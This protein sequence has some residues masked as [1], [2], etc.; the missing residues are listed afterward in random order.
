MTAAEA[1]DSTAGSRWLVTGAAGMLGQDVLAVLKDAGIEAAGLGRADL[2]ITDPASVRAAVEGAAVVVNC[3]AWT[4]VDGAES[5]EEAATAV[6]GTGVRVLAEACAAAGARLLHVSTDYVLP[7]DATEPYAEDAATGPVNAYGRSKLVGEQAV[8]ELLPQDG[9]VV[10]TAWL[11][12]EHG[13]NFVATMLKL[14]AQRDTLDVV[15]DQ[16]GQPTWSY[17]LARRLVE[18]GLAALDGRAPGGV[19]HGTASGRTTWFGLARE[20][21]RL[22]GLDPERIRPTDS[23]AFVRPAVRPSF[24]VL[25]HDRWSAA[26]LEPLADWRVQLAEAI[27]RPAFADLRGLPSQG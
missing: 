22:S 1:V 26:G 6:N 13:P 15:D 10:R 27:T 21:Y 7:G 5:A 9:Y 17:A 23:T 3:A 2:D 12:G 19:Y 24:S 18:L 25:R 16:H 14:A 4:D 20:T 11:Y 8:A